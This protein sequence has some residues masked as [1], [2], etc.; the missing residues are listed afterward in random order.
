MK[1]ATRQMIGRLTRGARLRKIP[2][3]LLA[4]R[5]IQPKAPTASQGALRLFQQQPRAARTYGRIGE[6]EVRLA[7]GRKLGW[8][9]I[10]SDLYEVRRSAKGF[11]FEG[12]GSGHGLGMC[13]NGAAAMGEQGFKYSE[14]LAHYYPNSR[15]T[16]SR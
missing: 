2:R 8:D 14:I 12:Y 16:P 4:L 15:L 11:V 5:A 10:R 6:L 7:I 1:L 13:Q 9:R 3:G